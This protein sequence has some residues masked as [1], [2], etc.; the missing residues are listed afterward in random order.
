M[1]TIKYFGMLLA[2]LAMSVCF[3]SCSSDDDDEGGADAIYD[4][5]IEFS[6]L[7]KGDLSSSE[8]KEI[9]ASLNSINTEL[10]A[11]TDSQA[12]YVFNS[13][14]DELVDSY[15]TERWPDFKIKVSLKRQDGR[16]VSNKILVFSE[17]GCRIG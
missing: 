4:Y 16:E 1:K 5:Q 17:D 11:L 12:K 6:M 10:E 7:D 9:I 15:D 8:S 14:V 2:M 3:V 13:F